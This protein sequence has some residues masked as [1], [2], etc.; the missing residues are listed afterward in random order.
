MNI[1]TSFPERSA[2]IINITIFLSSIDYNRY[3]MLNSRKRQQQVFNKKMISNEYI[4]FEQTR[5]INRD[6]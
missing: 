2:E 3:F 1:M 4:I 6:K 5:F